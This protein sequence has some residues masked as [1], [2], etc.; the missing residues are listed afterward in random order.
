[1]ELKLCNKQKKW[2]LKN[3]YPVFDENKVKCVV[4]HWVSAIAVYSK[5]K[6]VSHAWV[7]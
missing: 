1:M 3:D 7:K 4:L 6:H 5:A 2:S